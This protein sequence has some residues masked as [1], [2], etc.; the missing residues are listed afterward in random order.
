MNPQPASPVREPTLATSGLATCW[1]TLSVSSRTSSMPARRGAT[2]PPAA[3]QRGDVSGG[4]AAG[5]A[6]GG[7]AS[8]PGRDRLLRCREGAAGE[9]IGPEERRRD[10]R[11]LGI[12]TLLVE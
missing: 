8:R 10:G 6:P 2:G 11:L 12:S 1:R 4:R 7:R 5:A 9:H 3:I